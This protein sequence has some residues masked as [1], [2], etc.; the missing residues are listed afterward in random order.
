MMYLSS[1]P[2]GLTL[3]VIRSRCLRLSLPQPLAG[4]FL[5]LALLDLGH[6]LDQWLLDFQSRQ[7][8]LADLAVRVVLAGRIRLA[9]CQTKQLCLE[10][11]SSS[12]P[13]FAE[14]VD[15]NRY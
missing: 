9:Q 14:S 8:F 11:H 2:L 5:P 12:S 15:S 10:P 7:C 1:K 4:R 3:L 6:R 13:G